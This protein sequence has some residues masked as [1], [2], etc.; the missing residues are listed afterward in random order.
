MTVKHDSVLNAW[1]NCG[2][3]YDH[4]MEKKSFFQSPSKIIQ[5]GETDLKH[6]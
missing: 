3:I 6:R 1:P 4:N 2:H 5:H